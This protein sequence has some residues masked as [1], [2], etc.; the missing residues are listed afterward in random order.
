MKKIVF[1][2][3]S[4]LKSAIAT[5][6]ELAF[7]LR[8][9]GGYF[10]LRPLGRS[11]GFLCVELAAKKT[12]AK[13]T[14]GKTA[15]TQNAPSGKPTKSYFCGRSGCLGA[16]SRRRLVGGGVS[17]RPFKGTRAG[18]QKGCHLFPFT[19]KYDRVPFCEPRGI[20]LKKQPTL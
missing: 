6:N 20:A 14:A 18:E 12:R 3:E 5:K 8:V 13:P 4:R 19:G 2:G 9:F 1:C 7:F 10:Y 11:D 17:D 16:A 15:R